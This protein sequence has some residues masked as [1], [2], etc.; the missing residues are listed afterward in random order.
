MAHDN[1]A[2]KAGGP[3]LRLAPLG[4]AD[5]EYDD[6]APGGAIDWD[7]NASQTVAITGTPTGGTFTLTFT[8]PSDG[9]AQTT[10]TI[11][12]NAAAAA[13]TS[14]LEGLAG[15]GSGDVTVTGNNPT[16]TVTFGGALANTTIAALTASGSGL[17]G[18][19]A[20]GVTVTVVQ[21]GYGYTEPF[22]FDSEVEVAFVEKAD[23][24]QPIWALHRTHDTIVARGLDRVKSTMSQRSLA[25]LTYAHGANT[26]ASEA[27]DTDQVGRSILIPVDTATYY[28]GLLV[29]ESPSGGY[30][31]IALLKFR[32]EGDITQKFGHKRDSVP[33]VMKCFQDD[34]EETFNILE[35]TA[36]A[37]A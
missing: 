37:T 32:F 31:M 6:L 30:F 25:A 19:T 9:S 8:D 12:Y 11:A 18:G 27:A 1:D 14:A 20:P 34:N 26:V 2:I 4:T 29:M 22:Y 21:D 36:D 17:T 33:V 5:P 23:E 24:Y 35:Q 3:H 15:I 28:K 13:V 16:F 7:V 10:E